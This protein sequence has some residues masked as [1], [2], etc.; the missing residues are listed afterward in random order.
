MF[1]R[2]CIAVLCM[3]VIGST[4]AQTTTPPPQYPT[5][6]E[7]KKSGY[8]NDRFLSQLSLAIFRLY[9]GP[10]SELRRLYEGCTQAYDTGRCMQF[11]NYAEQLFKATSGPPYRGVIPEQWQDWTGGRINENQF[12]LYFMRVHLVEQ[13]SSQETI[14]RRECFMYSS[15]Y[16]CS[17]W[18]NILNARFLSEQKK[19]TANPW[20]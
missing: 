4:A 20:R 5:Y 9:F 11:L 2:T 19:T 18:L 10:P 15:D 8:A 3:A 1:L 13:T 17:R 16:D 6:Q 14:Y 12:N 7:L